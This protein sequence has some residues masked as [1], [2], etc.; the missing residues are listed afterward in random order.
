VAYSAT[1]GAIASMTLP[2]SRDLGRYGIRVVSIAPSAFSSAM[3]DRMPAK[4]RASL[5]RDT[6]F[7]QR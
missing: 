3:T 5:E 1:K 2:L 7:P 6:V 4:V